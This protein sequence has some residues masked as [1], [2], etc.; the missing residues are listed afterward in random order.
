MSRG[1]SRRDARR[2]RAGAAGSTVPDAAPAA[3]GAAPGAA[4]APA[5]GAAASAAVPAASA[6]ARAGAGTATAGPPSPSTAGT[7]PGR[8]GRRTLLVSIGAIAVLFAVAGVLRLWDLPLAPFHN[9]E[10][11][12]GWF[13]T[14]LLRNGTWSYDPANYHGPTLFY[15]EALSGLLVGL[16]DVSMRL[17]PAVF[18]LGTLGLVLLTARWIG[19]AGALAAAVLL[20]VSPGMVFFSRYAIHEMLLLF[21]T[22]ALVLAA[23]RWWESG[24]ARYFLVAA[25]AAAGM[26][27][28]KETAIITLAVLALA[29][30]C[31]GAYDRLAPRALGRPTRFAPGPGTAPPAESMEIPPGS[32]RR[33]ARRAQPADPLARFGGRDRL[34]ASLAGGAA[35]F[36]AIWV[37]LFS[38]LFT[39]VPDGI[40][41]SVLSLATWTQ[42][43]GATQVSGP[44]AYVAWM[45]EEEMPILVLGLAGSAYVA[46]EGRSRFAIFSAAWA[47]G[48]LLAYSL[49]GYK[50]PWL[51]LNWLL[52]YGIVAGYA[53]ARAW[54]GRRRVVRIAAAAALVAAVALSAVQAAQLAF[55]DY[56]R[57]ENA[58]VY[59]QT[60]RDALALIE[61]LR[62][63]DQRLGTD[64][65]LG[66]VVMSPDYWPLPWYLRDDL[67]AGFYAEV[68]DVEA[69]VQIVK[70]DQLDELPAGFA[71]RYREESRYTLRPGVELV[72]FAER[73]P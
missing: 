48:L 34:L 49:I 13:T 54:A 27:T 45:A 56:D 62:A 59:A 19:R 64:G 41:D 30:A 3:G 36:G 32:V 51:M 52:P 55:R 6:A 40:V 61:W 71:D 20:A 26:F 29:A 60:Q 68:V 58:Y 53:L 44:L 57:E 11:V 28:T 63:E 10:G 8:P 37:T 66:I 5:A 73:G 14:Q 67:K 2:R 9:D 15:A 35:V 1:S 21:F 42:T 39:N 43:S 4:A 31:L 70:A 46:W 22:L 65:Q 12:N 72:V 7:G 47:T 25:A 69:P 18:G 17:V 23:A 24:R 33:G 38:S 16:G 50:T